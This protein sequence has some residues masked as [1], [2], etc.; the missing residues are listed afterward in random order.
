MTRAHYGSILKAGGK[1]YEYSPGFNHAKTVISDD[2]YAFIGTINCDYRS[3]LLHFECGAL[4]LLNDQIPKMKEDFLSAVSLS[5][6]IT[7]EKWRRRPLFTKITE[8]LLS[9]I[10]PML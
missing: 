1:I 3:M 5:E 4:L 10:S 2:K 7:Y 6:E 9:L 8:M